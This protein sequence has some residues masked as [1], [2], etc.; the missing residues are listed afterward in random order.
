M[1][2]VSL[3]VRTC[4]VS[5]LERSSRLQSNKYD[6]S[7]EP[8]P[9]PPSVQYPLEGHHILTIPGTVREM[10][11]EALFERDEDA[12]TLATMVLDALLKVRKSCT[13]HVNKDG[14]REGIRKRVC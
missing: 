2:C 11:T 1:I 4:F 6:R 9:P 13:V 5:T 8:P 7:L 14:I 3:S 10:A 12:L